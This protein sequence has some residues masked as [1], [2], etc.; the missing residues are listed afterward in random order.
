MFVHTRKT[1]LAV[2][3]TALLVGT[4][5]AKEPSQKA[6]ARCGWFDNPTPGNASL[7]DRD[8]EWIIGIQGGHQAEGDW[9]SFKTSQWVNTNRSYGHGCACLKVVVKPRTHEVA[10]IRST[11]AHALDVCRK[12][13]AL[14]EPAS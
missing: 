11:Y 4:A 13:P 5:C 1:L 14:K 8:G 2:I 3:C 7:F 9:P 6:Q 10:R 12:D